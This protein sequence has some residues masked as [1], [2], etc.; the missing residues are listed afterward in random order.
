MPSARNE[1]RPVDYA[2]LIQSA[3]RSLE[4]SCCE[5]GDP[6]F[7]LEN[8]LEAFEGLVADVEDLR[9]LCQPKPQL[10][11]IMQHLD[12]SP[13]ALAEASHL[14]PVIVTREAESEDVA[15]L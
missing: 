14:K 2:Y 5:D 12:F 9:A 13:R 6:K 3:R 15:P 4:S 8:L 11:G 1:H 7:A 10:D